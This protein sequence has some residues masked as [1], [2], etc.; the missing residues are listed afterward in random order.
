MKPL[1]YCCPSWFWG[2]TGTGTWAGG[3]TC[4][5]TWGQWLLWMWIWFWFNRFL[6]FRQLKQTLCL[7]W[8]AISRVLAHRLQ[9]PIFS[10]LVR[11]ILSFSRHRWHT[12]NWPEV[13]GDVL[14]LVI[15]RLSSGPEQWTHLPWAARLAFLVRRF[16]LHEGQST[17]FC[18]SGGISDPHLRQAPCLSLVFFC[19]RLDLWR[20]RSRQC[21]QSLNIFGS[22]IGL[23]SSLDCGMMMCWSKSFLHLE[24]D[25]RR[26]L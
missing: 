21:W 17:N 20:W 10:R 5:W 2:W 26:M 11:R 24:H 12:L 1:L 22:T 3:C 7:P 23:D 18:W 14:L 6:R 19:H 25:D 9:L 13:F 15:I 16:C 8:S 4:G